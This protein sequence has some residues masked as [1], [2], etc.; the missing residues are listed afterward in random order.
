MAD[1]SKD[2]VEMFAVLAVDKYD[3]QR[4]FVDVMLWNSIFGLLSDKY[5]IKWPTV[6]EAQ[7]WRA[8]NQD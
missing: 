1:L 6:E 8:K 2:T 7:D 5:G 4:K 3:E